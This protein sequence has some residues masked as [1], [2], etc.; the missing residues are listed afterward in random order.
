[1]T[2][3]LVTEVPTLA[4][5]VK[6]QASRLR[7]IWLCVAAPAASGDDIFIANRS[8]ADVELPSG[9]LVAGFYSGKWFHCSGDAVTD[10]AK[11]APFILSGSDD[12]V[13]V[14]GIM[15]TV[16]DACDRNQSRKVQHHTLE[17]DPLPNA[18]WP[19]QAHPPT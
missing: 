13:L 8:D 3:V 9:S 7:D 10:P 17:P 19:L 5:E 4:H 18:P 15:M 16:G 2:E 14:G 1:M 6:F 11:D 12:L